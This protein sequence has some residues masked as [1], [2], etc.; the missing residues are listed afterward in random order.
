MNMLINLYVFCLI[1]FIRYPLTSETP[2]ESTSLTWLIP[3]CLPLRD[4]MPFTQPTATERS[5]MPFPNFD[6]LAT[7]HVT[8]DQN[9]TSE[10]HPLSNL[11]PRQHIG[12]FLYLSRPHKSQL[13]SILIHKHVRGEKMCKYRQTL[14]Q[15]FESLQQNMSISSTYCKTVTFSCNP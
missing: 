13:L 6:N 15:A 4:D 3:I 10:V 1:L 5:P 9:T 8:V 14:P 7:C 2:E 11:A 12:S